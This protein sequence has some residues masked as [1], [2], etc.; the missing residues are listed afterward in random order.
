MVSE[1]ELEKAEL[2]VMVDNQQFTILKPVL[3]YVKD[4]DKLQEIIA[5]VD[6]TNIVFVTFESLM[7]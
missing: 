3:R 5:S 1:S 6:P 4:K 2:V 7:A